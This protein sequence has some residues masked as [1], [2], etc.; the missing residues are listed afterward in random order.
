MNIHSILN[1]PVIVNDQTIHV[2]YS[3]RRKLLAV[4]EMQ[5]CSKS[6]EQCERRGKNNVN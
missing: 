5:A 4:S 3:I 6:I 1:I 2:I